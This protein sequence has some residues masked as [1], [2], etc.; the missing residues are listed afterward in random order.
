[1]QRISLWECVYAIYWVLILYYTFSMVRARAD[2][3]DE[4]WLRDVYMYIVL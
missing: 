3:D 4:P 2:D 1:M